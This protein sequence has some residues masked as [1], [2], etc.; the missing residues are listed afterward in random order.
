M[1]IYLNKNANLEKIVKDLLKVLGNE[2]IY[3]NIDNETNNNSIITKY[4]K[5]QTFDIFNYYDFKN[6]IENANSSITL[7]I[8]NLSNHFLI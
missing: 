2:L 6:Y 3:K 1:N 7:K 4:E 8:R 5:L